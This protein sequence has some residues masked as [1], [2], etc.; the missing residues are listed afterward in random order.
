MGPRRR[1][2]AWLGCSLTA[3]LSVLAVFLV[4]AHLGGR[5]APVQELK[6]WPGSSVAMGSG[7]SRWWDVLAAAVLGPFLLLALGGRGAREPEK[8]AGLPKY[9]TATFVAFL[10][11]GLAAGLSGLLIGLVAPLASGLL[12]GAIVGLVVG[13]P[14]GWR[15]V[16]VDGADAGSVIAAG[17]G[18]GIGLTN[19]L[20]IG[21]A[22]ALMAVPLVL[23]FYGLGYY[24]A[25][26]CKAALGRAGHHG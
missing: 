5:I 26:G 7:L 8:I 24:L 25:H 17:C 11:L 1:T 23:L 19:C 16:A 9:A 21:L 6:F 18:V 15:T 10:A 22:V 4:V 2:V 20:L 3:A 12:I 14:E 13:K